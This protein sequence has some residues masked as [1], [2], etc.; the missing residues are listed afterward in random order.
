MK[1]D[2]VD[3][4]GFAA[5]RRAGHADQVRLAGM[6]EELVQRLAALGGVVFHQGEQARQGEPVPGQDGLGGGHSMTSCGNH[7][8]FTAARTSSMICPVGAPGP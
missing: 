1:R 2:L 3:Q 5:A 8:A 7:Q 4:R 6:R